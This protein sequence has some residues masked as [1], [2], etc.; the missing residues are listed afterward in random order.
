LIDF[1]FFKVKKLIEVSNND[2]P[3]FVIQQMASF[4]QYRKNNPQQTDTDVQM[5]CTEQLQVKKP[6][7]QE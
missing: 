5:S 3:D 4:F 1:S 7:V 6:K 2:E